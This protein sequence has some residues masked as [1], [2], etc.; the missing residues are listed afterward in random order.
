MSHCLRWTAVTEGFKTL[1]RYRGSDLYAPTQT[2][3]IIYKHSWSDSLINNSTIQ[4]TINI[5]SCCWGVDTML[6]CLRW[7]AVGV[8]HVINTLPHKHLP[9][10][11]T[12]ELFWRYCHHAVQ[13]RADGTYLGFNS[14]SVSYTPKICSPS[15]TITF[16]GCLWI[17]HFWSCVTPRLQHIPTTFNFTNP[18]IKYTNNIALTPFTLSFKHTLLH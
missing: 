16:K 6:Y 18:N 14:S 13:T 11:C 15:H 17:S 7:T 3:Q 1:G 5:G 2:Q 10:P 12:K 4:H 8:V 9:Y